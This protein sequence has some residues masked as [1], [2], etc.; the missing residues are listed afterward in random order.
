MS[1]RQFRVEAAY[2][3]SSEGKL[4]AMTA[5]S[6]EDSTGMTS[7]ADN[8]CR[9]EIAALR[10][11]NAKLQARIREL[12]ERWSNPTLVLKRAYQAIEQQHA[13]K[14]IALFVA[15]TM[16]AREILDIIF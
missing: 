8:P 11:E 12:E 13:H 2:V 3:R 14:L 10:A 4:T 7:M 1:H 16:S 9:D 15:F 6:S 5:A